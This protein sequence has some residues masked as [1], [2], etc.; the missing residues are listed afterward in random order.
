[1]A[2]AEIKYE[3]KE[4]IG[5]IEKKGNKSI[6]LRIVAWNGGEPLPDIRPWWTDDDGN[7]KCGKGIRLTEEGLQKLA[8]II[9]GIEVEI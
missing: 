3:V 7:E 1:M 5:V 4:T 2:K 9:D 6:E 8:E